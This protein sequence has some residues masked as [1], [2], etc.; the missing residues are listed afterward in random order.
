MTYA[1]FINPHSPFVF[2]KNGEKTSLKNMYNWKDPDN[3]LNQYIYITSEIKKVI[4]ILIKKPN[5]LIIIQSDHGPRGDDFFIIDNKE[6]EDDAIAQSV[7]ICH[8]NKQNLN[9]ISSCKQQ[10]PQWYNNTFS[11]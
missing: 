4:E 5:T 8:R 10:R 7:A 2:D 3:Y 9:E 11:S 6:T 1:H